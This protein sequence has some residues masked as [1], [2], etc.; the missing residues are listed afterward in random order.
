MVAAL[1]HPRVTEIQGQ[2]VWVA[3]SEVREQWDLLDLAIRVD[4]SLEFYEGLILPEV[5]GLLACHPDVTRYDAEI[6][7]K[8]REHR[9]CAPWAVLLGGKAA[10]AHHHMDFATTFRSEAAF[11]AL[12]E[13]VAQTLGK[14]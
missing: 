8:A 12:P 3:H 5:Q 6:F 4:D 13:F 7:A 11:N 9:W 2:E 14:I 10:L 1:R